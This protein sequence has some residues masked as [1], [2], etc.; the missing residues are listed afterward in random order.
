MHFIVSK[1]SAVI[2]DW[3][4]LRLFNRKDRHHQVGLFTLLWAE[5]MPACT[6]KTSPLQVETSVN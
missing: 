5:A 2:A 4:F 1:I 6:G 3:K